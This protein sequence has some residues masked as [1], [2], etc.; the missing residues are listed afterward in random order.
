MKRFAIMVGMQQK[1]MRHSDIRTTMNITGDD[2][3]SEDARQTS[4]K[5]AQL[6]VRVV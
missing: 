5:V 3:V 6:A 2:V 1:A 4:Q